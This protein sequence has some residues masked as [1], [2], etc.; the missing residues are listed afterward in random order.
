MANGQ[1]NEF[2]KIYLYS[3]TEDSSGVFLMELLM[4]TKSGDIQATLKSDKNDLVE[5]YVEYLTSALSPILLK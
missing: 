3:Q 2:W 5:M 4:S 1:V